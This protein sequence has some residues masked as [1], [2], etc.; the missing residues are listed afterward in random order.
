MGGGYLTVAS[1]STLIRAIPSPAT[2]P[3][4]GTP[5]TPHGSGA[6]TNHHHKSPHHQNNDVKDVFGQYEVSQEVSDLL[7]LLASLF[8]LGSPPSQVCL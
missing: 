6:F 7:L 8:R 5:S 4:A 3:A 2:R 1:L